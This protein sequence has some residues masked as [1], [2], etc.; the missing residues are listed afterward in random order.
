MKP[1]TIKATRIS[2][3]PTKDAGISTPES[4]VSNLQGGLAVLLENNVRLQSQLIEKI[5]P[6]LNPRPLKE[7][8]DTSV[9]C[10]GEPRSPLAL[11]L[12]QQSAL[13]ESR[14]RELEGI[15]ACV[16]I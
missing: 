16:E 5:Q 13:V 8:A 9:K 10:E 11:W 12:L 14:N 2:T 15:I 7:C 1:S 4:V 3:L 6:V